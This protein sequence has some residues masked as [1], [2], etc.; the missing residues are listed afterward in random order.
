VKWTWSNAGAL[1]KNMATS[2]SSPSCD[3][4]AW[5]KD[6][7]ERR[8]FRTVRL[9]ELSIAALLR[10]GERAS[11]AT[12]ARVSKTVDATEPDGISESA[13]LHNDEAYALYLQHAQSKLHCK[14]KQPTE[15]PS[16]ILERGPLRVTSDRDCGGAR[17]RYLRATKPEL[18]HRLLAA[19]KAYADME[20]RWLRTANDLLL[21]IMLVDRLLTDH[22]SN[23]VQPQ[24]LHRSLRV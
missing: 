24:E 4:P 14:Q 17:Q 20:D 18:V 23:R 7:Y 12:I 22:A 19:E 1:M 6:V 11:L 3:P 10:A 16:N 15:L 8:R 13:I 21:S 9:V 5:L 2:H